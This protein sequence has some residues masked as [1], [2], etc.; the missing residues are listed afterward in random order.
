MGML[1]FDLTCPFCLRDNAVLQAFSERLRDSNSQIADVAF[2]CRSCQ[3]VG[4]VVVYIDHHRIAPLK[5]SQQGHDIIIPSNS[6]EYE[7]LEVIP[8]IR[9]SSAPE[10]TPERAAKFFIESK[11]DFQRGRYETSVM[12]C[13]KVID[14]A[15]KALMGDEAKD[16]KLS[17]RISM[18]F[19]KGK[20][21]EDMKDWAHIVRI[22]S[23]G[24]VHSD[25]EFTKEEAEQIL[26]FTEVFLMYSFTLPAMIEKRRSEFDSA[27]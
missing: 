18:L 22:D 10:N 7:I 8:E 3:Q 26:G 23:N 27:E 12:N 20:I 16:E 21:T 14:I 24:A 15:T 1:S 4:V 11:D 13:R 2:K 5:N 6:N 17:Q 9:S 25:E 19:A